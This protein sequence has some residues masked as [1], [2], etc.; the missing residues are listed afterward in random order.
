MLAWVAVYF[1]FRSDAKAWFGK[2]EPDGA[3]APVAED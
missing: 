2:S 1:L 3:A